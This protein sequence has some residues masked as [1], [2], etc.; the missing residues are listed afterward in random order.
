MV[1]PDQ[2]HGDPDKIVTI[3]T[4][5]GQRLLKKTMNSGRFAGGML[6]AWQ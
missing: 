2:A 5:R 1:Q 6:V 4:Q 3:H